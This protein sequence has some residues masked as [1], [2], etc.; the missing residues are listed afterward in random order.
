[1]YFI[2]LLF[3][4]IVTDSVVLD[5]LKVFIRFK[6]SNGVCWKYEGDLK[7]VKIITKPLK[8]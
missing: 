7:L 4:E 3:K 8:S 2:S 6:W 1:M 5:V